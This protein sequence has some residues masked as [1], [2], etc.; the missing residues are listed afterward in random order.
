MLPLFS[1]RGCFLRVS[2]LLLILWFGAQFLTA[3]EILEGPG[4]PKSGRDLFI[5]KGCIR[6]HSVWESGGKRGPNLA[7]VGM[8]R[9]LYELCASV[10]S[11]WS[12]MNA[13]LENNNE[14]RASLAANEFRDIIAYVG[15]GGLESRDKHV[16]S[17]VTTPDQ[18]ARVSGERSC[19]S[20]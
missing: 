4:N 12:R 13:V 17:N 18:M 15:S 11:H 6:C 7:T 1:K 2:P 10:W 19:R 8:G 14:T 20:G 5:N 9:N 16:A 3:K